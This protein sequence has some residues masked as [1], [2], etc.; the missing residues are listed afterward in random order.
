ML[1][2]KGRLTLDRDVLL[3]IKQALR[4][5]KVSLIALSPEIGVSAANLPRSVPADPADRLIAASALHLGAGLVTR[6]R[7]L[8]AF[9]PVQTI[10]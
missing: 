10:W 3:W 6:D 8:Q 2:S 7:A 1:V 5:P 9:P 4:R